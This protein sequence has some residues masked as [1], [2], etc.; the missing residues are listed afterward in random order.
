MNG[1]RRFT[2]AIILIFIGATAACNS[3]LVGGIP[4]ATPTT[5]HGKDVAEHGLLTSVI[6]KSPEKELETSKEVTSTV[7]PF[8]DERQELIPIDE[9]HFEGDFLRTLLK[10]KID[11][12]GDGYLS[13]MERERVD[14][15]GFDLDYLWANPTMDIIKDEA[16]ATSYETFFQYFPNLKLFECPRATAIVVRNHDA[17]RNVSHM[18]ETG[19]RDKIIVEGCPNFMGMYAG[20]VCELVSVTDVP[21]GV[22][23]IEPYN[24]KPKYV[25][26]G[27]IY[28]RQYSDDPYERD[29][30]YFLDEADLAWV[31]LKAS[32]VGYKKEDV[33][34]WVR[35]GVFDEF[36][37]EVF[38]KVEDIYNEKGVKGWNICVN[39]KEDIY[40]KYLFSLYC[41]QIPEA[42]AFKTKV[43][44]VLEF[45]PLVYSPNRGVYG[46]VVLELEVVYESDVGE[47]IIGTIEKKRYCFIEPS[48]ATAFYRTEE[49]WSI[50]DYEKLDYEIENPCYW[51][52]SDYLEYYN[53]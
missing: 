10:Q 26:D 45:T 2:C 27:N 30:R 18:C 31:N 49:E 12:D 34:P 1:K 21:Q 24:L 36:S 4:K 7:Q 19:T 9:E 6:T 5:V 32:F 42:E 46:Y 38:E 33:E 23:V 3:P 50:P 17:I 8:F 25:F 20:D 41:N 35:G 53:K 37:Y 16:K 28:V 22:V 48:G 43:S 40:G 39:T 29:L 51:Y 14:H 13:K 44:K 15:I 52:I 47:Q 11:L